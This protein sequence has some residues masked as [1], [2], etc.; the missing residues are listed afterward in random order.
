MLFKTSRQIGIAVLGLF[1]MVPAISAQSRPTKT[2]GKVTGV[3][4]RPLK[5]GPQ[6]IKCPAK[7]TFYGTITTDGPAKVKYTWVSSDGRSWP[8]TTL[9]FGA[10]GTKSVSVVWEL[11]KPGQNVNAWI[12]LEALSPNKVESTKTTFSFRCK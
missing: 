8:E 11:G 3:Q 12:Q 5:T 10:K 7:P 1:L 9:T 6:K 4:L 2:A